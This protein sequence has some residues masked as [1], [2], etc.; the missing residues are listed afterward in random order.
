[1]ESNQHRERI[2]SP[3]PVTEPFRQNLNA[4][5][6]SARIISSIWQ[7]PLPNLIPLELWE[8]PG[9]HRIPAGISGGQ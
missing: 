6:N 3:I 7:A 2:G 4:V 8:L 1:M 5:Q 9:F